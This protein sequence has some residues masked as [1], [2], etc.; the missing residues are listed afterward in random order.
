MASSFWKVFVEILITP[1]HHQELVW[2]I[3]PLYFAWVLNEMTSAKASYSTA[4]QTGFSFL[5]ACAQWIYPFLRDHAHVSAHR[6]KLGHLIGVNLAVTLL[7]SLIGVLALWSGITRR[8]PKYCSFLGHTR[9]SNY[10]M[11]TIF[12]LQASYLP[13]T[14]TRLFA[15]LVFAIPAWIIV[16]LLFL[17][18]RSR[19]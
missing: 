3:V 14:F 6:L 13:W 17:P 11:I 2:G 1:F 9:F 4:I 12:P 18:L 15:I 10:F 7:V 19:N 16:S 5:W 8:Y